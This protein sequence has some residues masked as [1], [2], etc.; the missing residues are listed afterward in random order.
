LKSLILLFSLIITTNLYANS[1]SDVYELS[2]EIKEAMNKLMESHARMINYINTRIEEL[3]KI[4]NR[5]F[6]EEQELSAL[7]LVQE[8]DQVKINNY[9]RLRKEFE[10]NKDNYFKLMY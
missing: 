1:N 6:V 2:S 7:L 9:L 4:K 5:N 3:L 8:G 10:N